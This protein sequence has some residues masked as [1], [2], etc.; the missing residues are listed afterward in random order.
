MVMLHTNQSEPFLTPCSSAVVVPAFCAD[1][2]VTREKAQ[3]EEENRRELGRATLQAA[4]N[5]HIATAEAAIAVSVHERP[6][7]VAA[8]R[9]YES[10][11]STARLAEVTLNCNHKYDDCNRTHLL[12][13]AAYR[14]SS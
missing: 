10:A 11:L 2:V 6:D 3:R 1:Q 5:R 7:M 14:L 8:L 13:T 9:G 4:A 12:S